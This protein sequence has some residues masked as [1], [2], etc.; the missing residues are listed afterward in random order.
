MRDDYCFPSGFWYDS[1]WNAADSPFISDAELD[2]FNADRKTKDFEDYLNGMASVYRGNHI[3]ITMGCDFTYANAKMDFEN[4]DRLIQ[5][6]NANNDQNMIL[7]YSTPGEYLQALH[8]QN[9][10]WPT[11]Y[12]DMFPYGTGTD[13]WVGY[14]TSRQSS[15]K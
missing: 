2:N 3:M 15:K 4:T 6:F 5:Y 7:Q 13:Y 10:T 8:S 12:D 1:R 9:I 14:Y 11:K